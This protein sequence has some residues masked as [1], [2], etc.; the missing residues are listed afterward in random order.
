LHS[1]RT[2]S[3]A[4]IDRR[5]LHVPAVEEIGESLRV[6]RFEASLRLAGV[7]EGRRDLEHAFEISDRVVIAELHVATGGLELGV[8]RDLISTL[9]H[10]SPGRCIRNTLTPARL[11]SE[12]LRRDVSMRVHVL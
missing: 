6:Q 7:A 3:L 9:P 11:G 5:L 1:E 2:G 10:G 12:R 8:L 4:V